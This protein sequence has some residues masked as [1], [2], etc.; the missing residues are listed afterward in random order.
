MV[1]TWDYEED[2]HLPLA[3]Q[4]R[5]RMEAEYGPLFVK[6]KKMLGQSV[7][8]T[9]PNRNILTGTVI[10]IEKS[11]FIDSTGEKP[12]RRRY[13]PRYVVKVAG[14]RGHFILYANDLITAPESK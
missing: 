11:Y 2:S 8:F 1:K 9:S 14:N 4:Q 10:W 12:H 6:Y 13:F 7:R 5:M 3:E